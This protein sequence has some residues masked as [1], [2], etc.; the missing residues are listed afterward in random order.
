LFK[1]LI[2]IFGCDSFVQQKT[3]LLRGRDTTL[4]IV[5]SCNPSDTG[6][7]FKR[8]INIVGCDSFVRQRTILLRGR[9]TTVLNF[10]SC[11]PRDTGIVFKRLI[12][13][14]GCDSFVRQKTIL[15]RGRDTTFL[16]F[17]SCNPSDTGVV[18]RRFAN[19]VGCDSFVRGKTILL[20]GR[21]TTFLTATTCNPRDTGLV[22]LKLLNINGCDSFVSLRKKFY[23]LSI[24][25]V[26]LP[27][28]CTGETGAVNITKTIGGKSPYQYALQDTAHYQSSPVFNNLHSRM[29]SLFVKDAFKCTHR[30]D[31]FQV[32]KSRCQVFSPNQDGQND[33]FEFYASSH[34]I[35]TV[36]TYRIFNRWGDLVYDAPNKNVP[37]NQFS[38]WWDGTF[39]N[40]LLPPD[41]FVY[42]IEVDYFDESNTDN[43]KILKGGVTLIR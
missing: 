15:L 14:V 21:D 18:L 30:F 2:N 11:N 4:S 16:N 32:K 8:L 25:A 31:S 13:S 34:Y 43:E 33:K 3:I 28:D 24:E 17:S 20:R 27:T 19:S 41:V 9:D 26:T 37:F 5:T 10:A 38:D 40:Q 12:N 36:K 23:P 29:Y 39:M 22:M 6:I 7:V 1:R 35:K 42:V